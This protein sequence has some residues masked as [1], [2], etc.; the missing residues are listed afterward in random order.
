MTVVIGAGAA[1]IVMVLFAAAACYLTRDTG[2][3]A[4]RDTE[5]PFAGWRMPPEIAHE[6]P[7]YEPIPL[8]LNEYLPAPAQTSPARSFPHPPMREPGTPAA[9]TSTPQV[10]A[11]PIPERVPAAA[12]EATAAAGRIH[13]A[14]RAIKELSG[15]EYLRHL[16]ASTEW[17]HSTGWFAAIGGGAP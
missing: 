9:T 2:T 16:Q 14:V 17:E 15:D 7:R 12:D 4:R 3:R 5:N 13:G 8:A 1:A 11:R 10:A 6:I